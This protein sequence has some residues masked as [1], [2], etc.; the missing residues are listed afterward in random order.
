[1]GSGVCNWTGPTTPA[2]IGII[3]RCRL[4]Q[5][6][7][8]LCYAADCLQV[9]QN[10]LVVFVPKYG[11][12][13]PVY[14]TPK[15]AANNA[16]QALQFILDEEKQTVA[17][18]DGSVR[19]AV[20]DKCAVRISVEEGASHRRSLVLALVPRSELPPADQLG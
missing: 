15:D 16:N 8:I 1:M 18:T 13:G 6:H 14:L 17:S 9:K 7:T 3:T 12:E 4:C 11:I 2:C 5:H 10:G 19:F 20:F